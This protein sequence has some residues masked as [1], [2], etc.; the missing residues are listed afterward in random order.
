MTKDSDSSPLLVQQAWRG[1]PNRL[2]DLIKKNA[3]MPPSTPPM[4]FIEPN[5]S[6]LNWFF[7]KINKKDNNKNDNTINTTNNNNKHDSVWD[8][9]TDV[10]LRAI[11]HHIPL[12]THTNQNQQQKQPTI[13]THD[14]NELRHIYVATLGKLKNL[15]NYTLIQQLSLHKLVVIIQKVI[16]SN[17]SNGLYTIKLFQRD[18]IS[19][20]SNSAV[21]AVT[22]IT[23]GRGVTSSDFILNKR[24]PLKRTRYIYMLLNTPASEVK[25][26]L[27]PVT[28]SYQKLR[29]PYVDT[30]IVIS[31]DIEEK[32]IKEKP[33]LEKQQQEENEEEDWL[34]R[35]HSLSSNGSSSSNSSSSSCNSSEIAISIETNNIGTDKVKNDAKTFKFVPADFLLDPA[36]LRT[37]NGNGGDTRI[38]TTIT[39]GSRFG[40]K[41]NQQE[42][43]LEPQFIFQDPTEKKKA[44]KRTKSI[45]SRFKIK[46]IDRIQMQ[47]VKDNYFII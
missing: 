11:T 1:F 30:A 4:A 14:T 32:E 9:Y 34:N 36:T 20:L 33:V 25:D 37:K 45:L 39:T 40:T 7:P 24:S 3:T 8:H 19:I 13:K 29:R 16:S 5:K 22:G 12:F 35:S 28:E 47:E 43:P 26:K 10:P 46:A 23:R 6:L 31:N 44:C 38:I 18:C 27:H 21:A 17:S 42:Q 2:K 41:L 15:N